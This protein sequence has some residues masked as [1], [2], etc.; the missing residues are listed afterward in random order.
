MIEN[1]KFLAIFW[2]S[3]G[4]F[5]EGQ[6]VTYSQDKTQNLEVH[7]D[8]RPTP[9]QYIDKFSYDWSNNS[10]R[11]TCDNLLHIKNNEI[12]ESLSKQTVKIM[13]ASIQI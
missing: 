7:T 10:K 5:P 9:R 4:N 1:V 13:F 12:C 11:D 3:N 6:V 2:Q 8:R